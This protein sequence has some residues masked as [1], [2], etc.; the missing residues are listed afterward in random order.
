MQTTECDGAWEVGVVVP[1]HGRPALLR[2]ALTS[3]LVQRRLPL[4]V[5]VVDDID[6][7]ATAEVVEEVQRSA[8]IPVRRILGPAEGGASSSRN[9][10]A[11]AVRGDALAFLD[12]DD[13]WREGFLAAVIPLLD[14]VAVACAWIHFAPDRLGAEVTLRRLPTGLTPSQALGRNRGVTGS[15][16]AVRRDAFLAVGGFD[17]SLRVGNDHDFFGRLLD[18]GCSYDVVR[19]P[20]VDQRVHEGARLTTDWRRRA[21]GLERYLSRHDSRLSRRD[22][23]HL[24]AMIADVRFHA[25]TGP[26][27]RMVEALRWLGFATPS[28]LAERVRR[29][30]RNRPSAGARHRLPRPVMDCDGRHGAA[31]GSDAART[32]TPDEQLPV[33]TGADGPAVTV[34]IPVKD[35]EGRLRG[36]LEAL[37]QQSYPA[38]LVEVIVVDNGSEPPVPEGLG[39]PGTR[40]LRES[41]PG[42]YAAR[43]RA[44]E[45]ARGGV[46]AF[47]DADCLPLPDWLRAGVDV[48][49]REEADYVVGR[50]E[51]VAAN[52][53]PTLAERY[54]CAEAFPQE[55]YAR[56]GFGATANLLV[57]REAFDLV[58]VFDPALRSGGDREWGRKAAAAGLR[59]VYAASAVVQHPARRTLG[60]LT[61]KL[62]RVMAGQWQANSSLRWAA[63]TVRAHLALGLKAAG[64][65]LRRLPDDPL[66]A[67]AVTGV[68]V[69]VRAWS[70]ALLARLVLRE[71]RPPQG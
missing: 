22:R 70:L 67:L 69:L 27:E 56:H 6:D 63:R 35:D 34:V 4:E 28:D 8:V 50:I 43:N 45:V 42:S 15:S 7:G 23:R 46:M 5:V 14:Q 9:A 52:S 53:R 37:A 66:D 20:L 49:L 38:N 58:G 44:L 59:S 24:R 29:K 48:L 31:F 12:D 65:A 61:E 25:A 10:G 21:E 32:R 3:V 18:A 64:R 57:R 36:C 54:E 51:V 16:L 19:V 1:T 41:R 11:A 47:T 33:V 13:T 55:R 30:S 39:P 62:D 60:E 40:V 2:R 17:E 68:V 71:L 26:R